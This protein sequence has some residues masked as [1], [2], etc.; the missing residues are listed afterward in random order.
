MSYLTQAVEPAAQAA[1]AATMALRKDASMPY[2]PWDSLPEYWRR[3][4]RAQVSAV[5]PW[6]RAQGFR[7]AAV[8]AQDYPDPETFQRV[9]Y[10]FAAIA[11][12][13]ECDRS[14]MLRS[15][16][17]ERGVDHHP[18]GSIEARDDVEQDALPLGGAA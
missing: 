12:C 1:Y 11:E 8:Y 16:P 17:L 10:R 3:I 13:A 18:L 14:G 9:L 6:G 7:L 5:L 2:E 15:D 4:Y